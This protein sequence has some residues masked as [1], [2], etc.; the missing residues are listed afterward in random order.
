MSWEPIAE[1]EFRLMMAEQVLRLNNVLFPKWEMYGVMP[2]RLP[3]ERRN[4]AGQPLSEMVFVVARAADD[5]LIYDDVEEEFGTGRI[6]PD[7]VLRHWGTFG[8]ELAWALGAFVQNQ[9][10]SRFAP[11]EQ[12]G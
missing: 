5:V 8:E 9:D 4:L 3:C 1:S 6:D 11:P 10:V 7:G 2:E 12:A